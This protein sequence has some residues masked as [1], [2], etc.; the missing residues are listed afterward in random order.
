M[1]TRGVVAVRVQP[2]V[3][4]SLSLSSPHAG[5]GGRDPARGGDSGLSEPESRRPP[6]PPAPF[7]K[8]A[9]AP[10][11]AG[12]GVPGTAPLARDRL[13]PHPPRAACPPWDPQ[14]DTTGFAALAGLNP[15][16]LQGISVGKG[17]KSGTGGETVRVPGTQLS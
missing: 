4:L 17:V 15:L 11:R 1:A 12:H 5:V 2:R 7:T 6:L 8:N 13:L 9:T 14:T 10:A 3:S 16:D